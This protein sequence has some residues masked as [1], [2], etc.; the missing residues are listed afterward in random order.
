MAVDAAVPT[1]AGV[2]LA[3]PAAD[4]YPDGHQVVERSPAVPAVPEARSFIWTRPSTGRPKVQHSDELHAATSSG[5]SVRDLAAGDGGVGGCPAGILA[6]GDGHDP[7]GPA[8][9][10]AATA[11]AAAASG[12]P[13]EHNFDELHAATSSDASV[14][15]LAGGGV[16]GCPAGEA[17]SPLFL[18]G[19]G[20][21]DPAGPADVVAASAAAAAMV[22]TLPSTG[23]PKGLVRQAVA[24]IEHA[25][26]G[27][28]GAGLPPAGLPLTLFPLRGL[29]GQR[30]VHPR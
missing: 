14:R 27:P 21:H 23:V 26:H 12:R 30:E 20:G 22:W 19:G 3:V 5:V 9:A 24:N 10:V 11:A 15:D 8:G 2:S 1:P 18:A 28:A 4:T 6:D 17:R 29:H 13:K 16:G 25:V 7:A